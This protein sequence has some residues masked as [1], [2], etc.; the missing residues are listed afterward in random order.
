MLAAR[1]AQSWFPVLRPAAQSRRPPRKLRCRLTFS[2]SFSF[3]FLC[4]VCLPMFEH[5]IH[6][7]RARVLVHREFDVLQTQVPAA[8]LAVNEAETEVLKRLRLVE[9]HRFARARSRRIRER[10][11]K[12][13]GRVHFGAA[14]LME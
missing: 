8:A 4:S 11:D 10:K 3:S 7:D 6:S 5:L 2:D 12:G 9:G 13:P 14:L 1:S